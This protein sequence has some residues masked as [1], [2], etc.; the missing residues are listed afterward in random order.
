MSLW[1]DKRVAVTG[2]AGFLGSHVVTNLKKRGCR[3]IF[4][5]RSRD[6]DLREKEDI[7]R[8]YKDSSPHIV[9]HLAASMGGIGANLRNPGKFF[10]DNAI[11]GIHIIEQ[12]RLFDVEKTVIVGT[13]C[14]YPKYTPVPFKEENFWNGYPEDTNAAYGISK[15]MHLVQLQAYRRQYGLNSVYLILSNLYGPGE[16][17]DLENSHATGALIR[18]CYDAIEVGQGEIVVWGDGSATREFLYVDDAA[19]GILLATERYNKAEPVNLGSGKEISIKDLAEL[20]KKVTG[21][22]GTFVLD[23]AKPKG[24]PRR[25]VDIS[26]AE[27]EFGFKAKTEL[28]EGLRKTFEWYKQQR[29]R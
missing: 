20:I 14:S 18:K 16:S 19:E 1:R 26:K 24:H 12:A 25:C 5:P 29:S 2:G 3:E 7:T 27:K 21:F 15:K 22:K 8:M 9:I 17:F 28:E 13:A 6:Y 4:V 23:T 10:Y 11:M